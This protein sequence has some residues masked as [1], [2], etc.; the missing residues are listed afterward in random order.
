MVTT[1]RRPRR[2]LP[3]RALAVIGAMLLVV[4][5]SQVISTLTAHPLTSPTRPAPVDPQAPAVGD[6]DAGTISFGGPGE[7]ADAPASLDLDRIRAN[8]IF[9]SERVARDRDD[10]VSS[11]N[12]GIA[13]IE[14]ARSTGDLTAYLAADAAFETTLARDPRNAAALGYRGSV[15]VSLHRFPEAR[16]LAASVLSGRPDDPVAL[17]TLGDASL[18]LGDLDAAADAYGRAQTIAPSP[19]TEAR[20]AHLAFLR[21]DTATAVRLAR[22]AAADADEAGVDGER[23]AFYQYQLAD[24]LISTGD[25][26]GALT[27][28]Q[29]ALTAQPTSFLALTGLARVAAA[30]G[31][32]DAAI[33]RIS[34]AIA[35][36]PRPDSLARRADLYRLR[37]APGDERR[38]SDDRDTVEVIAQLAG[39]AAGVYDRTLAMDLADHGLE[40]ERAVSLAQ[41]ELA[42]RKDVYGFDAMAWTLLAAG[43]A[44]GADAAMQQALA[45]GTQDAK[46]LY[47]AGMIDAALGRTA[48]ART[49][50]ERALA[51]DPSFDP[52]QVQR[53]NETLDALSS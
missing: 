17:A 4:I 13:Q 51:L 33:A 37:G 11:N 23:A 34:E 45:V 48:D 18:E 32:L 35:I 10:F 16:T 21:G 27:A 1:A 46:L 38:A 31:D 42:V 52:L 26:P 8:I 24:V 28:Y 30:D 5:A 2:P 19:A 14:L 40:P 20:L 7:G 15:L 29:A 36:V 44:E 49:M 22:S 12:L 9:W 6:L 3:T 41:A 47:H 39:D 53:A 43:R 50:L 25:R